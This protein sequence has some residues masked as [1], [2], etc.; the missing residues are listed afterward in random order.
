MVELLLRGLEQ[1]DIREHRD[2]MADYALFIVDGA[3]ALP[4]RV[5][6]TVLA[7][8]PDLAAPAAVV[9]ELVPHALVEGTIMTTG[10]QQLRRAADDL[11]ER[12]A[13]D[14]GEG[15]VEVADAHLCVGHQH[16]FLGRIEHRS[17]LAQVADVLAQGV[18][19][20]QPATFLEAQGG[21]QNQP[22]N[23]YEHQPLDRTQVLERAEVGAE[24]AQ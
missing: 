2:V 15:R 6:F 7:P 4:L 17:G 21:E 18:Y 1:A 22:G 13:S 20:G 12:V 3:N 11:V 5:D 19:G 14:A 10:L 16:A 8:V 23:H 9:R 24:L